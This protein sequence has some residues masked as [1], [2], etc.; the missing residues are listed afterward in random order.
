[1]IIL[2]DFCACEKYLDLKTYLRLLHPHQKYACECVNVRTAQFSVKS[3]N[4][5][6]FTDEI[7]MVQFESG[8][9]DNG[10]A[11][12]TFNVQQR[13]FPSKNQVFL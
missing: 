9:G 11:E 6:K 2:K 7:Q 4:I 5:R 13:C 8:L 12:K 3:K 10:K 1:M